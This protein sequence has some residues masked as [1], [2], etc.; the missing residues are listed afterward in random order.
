MYVCNCIYIYIYI[1]THI[2][3][4]IYIYTHTYIYIYI[5]TYFFAECGGERVAW[6]S[7]QVQLQGVTPVCAPNL[8]GLGSR[9]RGGHSMYVCMY[10]CMHACMY[11]CMYVCMHVCMQREVVTTTVGFHNFKSQIFKLSVSNPKQKYMLL[12][13]PY[14]L[15]FQIARV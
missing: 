12:V 8:F 9:S 13:C 10:V 15:K 7:P 5:Y 3:I 6:H 2:Y 11:V 14:C 4:Y 1:Y